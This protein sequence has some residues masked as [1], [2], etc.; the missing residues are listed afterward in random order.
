V[1]DEGA[2]L[3]PVKPIE[4]FTT[5]AIEA[6]HESFG[7]A[8]DDVILLR[9]ASG[10]GK[11]SARRLADVNPHVV[12]KHGTL[13][14]QARAVLHE[15]EIPYGSAEGVTVQE[16]D[17]LAVARESE[18]EA[19]I[20]DWRDRATERRKEENASM[21]DELISEHRAERRKEQRSG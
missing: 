5:T 9:D 3:V 14:D 11:S 4:Q 8:E 7:L 16:I 21:V 19:V 1:A 13:S 18:V 12:L 2:D 6:A 15:H 20:D 10:A 17:E